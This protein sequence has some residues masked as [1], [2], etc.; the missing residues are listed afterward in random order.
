MII[1][2]CQENVRSIRI[3]LRCCFW[4][5]RPCKG[6][7][8]RTFCLENVNVTRSI[9]P[10]KKDN[11]SVYNIRKVYFSSLLSVSV[12]LKNKEHFQQR[13]PDQVEEI[14][15]WR[16]KISTPQFPKVYREI[17]RNNCNIGA[18]TVARVIILPL[19]VTVCFDL[20]LFN[21]IFLPLKLPSI[22]WMSLNPNESRHR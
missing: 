3:K 2:L 21:L 7:L 18:T 11:L 14:V 10:W 19:F 22:R 15:R 4:R 16:M 17:L 12:F 8:L 13:R 1:S 20:W 5:W 9:I 6:A